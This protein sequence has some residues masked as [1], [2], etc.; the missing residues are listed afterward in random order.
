MRASVVAGVVMRVLPTCFSNYLKIPS[1]SIGTKM[2]QSY[3]FDKMIN[4]GWTKDFLKDSGLNEETVD[5]YLS[6]R[7]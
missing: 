5:K 2:M 4:N 1:K 7:I 3:I 6:K